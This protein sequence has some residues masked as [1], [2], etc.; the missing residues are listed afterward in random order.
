M[1]Q[2]EQGDYLGWDQLVPKLD[3]SLVQI[4]R[5][6]LGFKRVTKTQAAV[7]PLFLSNKDVC[8]KACTGSG[9]TLAFGIPLVQTL[10][11]Y[12][13]QN[14]V[15]QESSDDEEAAEDKPSK[16]N[17]SKNQVV[18]L[19]MAP[20]RELAMQTMTVLRNFEHLLPQLSFCYLIG[21]NKIEYDLQRIKEKGANVIVATVGRL[22]DLSIEKKALSFSK[23]EVMVMDEADKMLDQGNEVQLQS[24]LQLLP[25]QRRTGLYS[26][27]MPTTLK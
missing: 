5:D 1:A 13:E 2:T 12:C 6:K 22:Y 3:D 26:A 7:V 10:L 23:L 19:L 14:I 4:L 16:L 18:G 20:S 24:V 27:T 15:A 17:L 9:K 11:K 21:G 25:K 8:V